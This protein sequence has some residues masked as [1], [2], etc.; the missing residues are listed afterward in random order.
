MRRSPARHALRARPPLGAGLPVL[1]CLLALAGCANVEPKPYYDHRE[2]GPRS[3]L[4]T[5]ARGEAVLV[6]DKAS[7]DGEPVPSRRLP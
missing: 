7:D 4:F 1:A 5:G 3:G 6:G 2:E